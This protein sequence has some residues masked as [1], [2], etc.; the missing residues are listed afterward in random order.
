[1]KTKLIINCNQQ[2]TVRVCEYND[3]KQQLKI[4]YLEK[5][6]LQVEMIATNKYL[7]IK[8]TG[9]I[10]FS[11]RHYQG[12]KKSVIVKIKFVDNNFEIKNSIYTHKYR[13]LKK[14]LS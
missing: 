14:K 11:Y 7:Q 1:M 4:N 3:D 10:N 12:Q 13:L 8:K 2:K 6:N 9:I 5:P